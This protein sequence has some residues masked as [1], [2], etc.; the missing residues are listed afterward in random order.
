[1]Q[2]CPVGLRNPQRGDPLSRRVAEGPGIHVNRIR[3]IVI[4]DGRDRTG[5]GVFVESTMLEAAG[6]PTPDTPPIAHE[7]EARAIEIWPMRLA[8]VLDESDPLLEPVM[9]P[10][11]PG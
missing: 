7:A 3:G 4:N 8:S 10:P 6:L 2:G 9:V 5:R 1:M 11:T